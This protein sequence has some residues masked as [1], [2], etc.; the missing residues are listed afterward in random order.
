MYLLQNYIV[1]HCNFNSKNAPNDD[2]DFLDQ[3]AKPIMT[4]EQVL[5]FL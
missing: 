4:K 5:L 2:D 3:I 1:K